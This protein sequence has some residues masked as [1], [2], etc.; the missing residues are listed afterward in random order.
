MHRVFIIAGLLVLSLAAF[1]STEPTLQ[2]LIARAD[3]ARP[4]DRPALYVDI[5]ER[6]LRSADQFYTDGKV[7]DAVAAVKNV[8]TYSEKA[9]DA[10]IQTGKR[11][12]NTEIALRNMARRLRDLK[13][14]LNFDDQPPV[15]DAA[16]RLQ[17][18]TD[19]LLMQMFGKK[20]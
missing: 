12:K 6:E 10:A 1:A 5:A 11:L 20:K 14:T 7:D 13:G 4:Q 19:D 2:E 18:L 17:N 3:A 9:H 8:V 15:G 16:N